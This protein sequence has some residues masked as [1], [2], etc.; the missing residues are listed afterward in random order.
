MK[1]PQVKMHGPEHHFLVPAVLLC[2]YYNFKKDKIN[3]EAA[4]RTALKRAE[5]IPGGFCG[6]HGNCGAAV[7]TGIFISIITKATPLSEEE[8]KL[9]NEINGHSLLAIAQQ[10][11]PRCCKRDS[12]TAIQVAIDFLAKHFAVTL[13]KNDIGCSFSHLNK[14]CKHSDCQYFQNIPS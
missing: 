10:G 9:S 12:Y 1:S 14:Q 13:P 3:K 7:G 4:I 8:W 2:A 11:G 6:S 5:L